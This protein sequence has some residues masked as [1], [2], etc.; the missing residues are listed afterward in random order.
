MKKTL[1]LL[2]AAFCGV[3]TAAAQDLIVKTD[4]SRIEAKVVEI[5]TDAVRYKKFSY[6]AGPTYVL[7]V[8]QIAYIRYANGETEYYAESVPA[9]ELT[10]A[11]PASCTTG[12]AC[13]ASS[14]AFRKT[15]GTGWSSRWTR[16]TSPGANSASPIC[17]RWGRRTVPTAGRT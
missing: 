3:L 6:P 2:L 1:L 7:P 12:T 10:P 14:A 5:T 17:G 4:A 16:F 11:E 9:A 15:G 13:G 8:K